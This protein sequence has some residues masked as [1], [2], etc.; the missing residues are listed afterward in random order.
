[1]PHL[2]TFFSNTRVMSPAPT[3]D[4]R[5]GCNACKSKRL[6]CGEER[7]NC[8]RCVRRGIPCPGYNTPLKWS[9]KHEMFGDRTKGWKD[10][11]GR[12][13]LKLTPPLADQRQ[14]SEDARIS[15]TDQ[16]S[17]DFSSLLDQAEDMHNSYFWPGTA[18]T[19]YWPF[20]PSPRAEESDY[21]Q[22][23]GGYLDP[24]AT[25]LY[26]RNTQPVS[27]SNVAFSGELQVLDNNCTDLFVGSGQAAV[28]NVGDAAELTQTLDGTRGLQAPDQ[29]GFGDPVAAPPS[30]RLVS[31]LL[32]GDD[33]DARRLL[34][35]SKTLN[36]DS[37]V[38][39]E[40]YFKDTARLFSCY[41]GNLNPFRTNVSTLW[42]SSPLIYHSLSSMAA[43]S[44]D[45]DF[46]QFRAMGREHRK[47]ALVLLEKEKTV[48]ETSLLAMLMLGGT[49][50]WHDPRDI[51]TPFFNKLAKCLERMGENGQL[52]QNAKNFRFFQ[53]AMMYWEMLLSFVVDSADLNRT[54]GSTLIDERSDDAR[55]VPH[56]WTGVARETQ[57]LV[58]EVGRLVRQQRKKAHLHRFT[59]Q[60][61]IRQMQKT[62]SH[63]GNLERQL[64]ALSHSAP[65]EDN[66][67]NPDDRETPLWHLLTLAEVYRRTGL[68]QLYRVFPDLL[69]GKAIFD[70]L[71]TILAHEGIACK[72][73]GGSDDVSDVPPALANDWLCRY[74]IATLELLR[75]IPIESGT[76]DFQPFLLVALC[77]ELRIES[78]TTQS[79]PVGKSPALADA[80]FRRD[81]DVITPC[82]G[83]PTA[84]A[85]AAVRARGLILSRLRSFLHVLPPRPIH[86]C[87]QIVKTSWEKMD[88]AAV[89]RA[90]RVRAAAGSQDV[91]SDL[92][93]INTV[94]S[95]SVEV[96]W[97]DVMMQHRWETT[98]A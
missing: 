17:N 95:E 59:T 64:L 8:L 36:D 2:S 60:A 82:I 48:N 77:S 62:L 91:N 37:S 76:R 28:V 15:A 23:A 26:A 5:P 53:E 13:K 9:T 96:Y 7:P 67:V 40:F 63:A 58:Q 61:H 94:E 92:S 25:G 69:Y 83:Q 41:D 70:G 46:P 24:Q 86:V 19:I 72:N 65:N 87:I 71:Q 11:R 84:D 85:L 57:Y 43:S 32:I 33:E 68:V 45:Q 54:G 73:A 78:D 74:T 35:L 12:R 22:H 1:M 56:P 18:E 3:N 14:H 97:L 80:Q 44:L 38:L 27:G 50:S 98:M 21:S 20:D 10:G 16:D 52:K 39:V 66:V 34:A 81:A 29:Q 75:T 30:S 93:D 88:E 55:Q 4:A 42:A 51:G 6:K 79:L 31:L 90:I 47:Q 49:A 89:Q